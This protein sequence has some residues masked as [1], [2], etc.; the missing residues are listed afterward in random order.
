M[1][2]FHYFTPTKIVFGKDT[3]QQVGALI[4]A[5]HC[6]KVLIHYGSQSAKKSGLLDRI[7]ASLDNAGI[8][9][10][11]LGGVVPNPL[12]SLV[13]QGI[14]LCK[15]E[16]VD[17]ILAVG[18]GSV[19]DSAKAIAYGVTEEGDVWD[20]FDG[21]RQAT[22]CLPV[23]TV[24][25]IAAAG[26]EMSDG[27]VI[28]KDEGG[29][30]RGYSNDLSRPKFSILN[31]ELTVTLPDYQTASGNADIL[32]HTMERYFTPNATMEITD[33]IAESILKTVMKNAQILVKDPKN[34]QA[35]AEIM[36]C[37]SLS[38]NGLTSC[39]G[40][41]G[42]WA[43]HMLEHELSG[44]FNV[45]HGAG[46]AAIWGHWARY[47]YRDILP[48]FER[49]AIHAMGVTPAQTA[50][51]T[52]LKGIEAMENFFRSINMPTN[53]TELGVSASTEQIAEMAHKCS[54]AGA[55]SVGTAKTLYEQDMVAIYTAA[56]NA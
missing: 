1:Q 31:P 14:E 23:A 30:K 5:Q 10:V 18:G 34:Y 4:K 49:F 28:T 35:R 24:L 2:N 29:I 27:S 45:T 25:T 20:L 9:Y 56:Q 42:D 46:L 22:A 19:I 38:H 44:M 55:G 36:W 52:A 40:G 15:R 21:K 13:Y 26:S 53:L 12:L 17:F 3:E 32:M 37:G 39:G 33:T 54:I 7:K 6:K 48:R 8:S 16:Q 50:E 41:N 51:Q 11:E 43:T 47:V